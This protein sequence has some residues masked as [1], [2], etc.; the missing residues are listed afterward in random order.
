MVK[1]E[2][3]A[4]EGTMDK[5]VAIVEARV[6]VSIAI[7][8]LL[9]ACTHGYLGIPASSNQCDWMNKIRFAR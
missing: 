8:C 2:G 9:I 3:T 5:V 1:A 7:E 6:T 4:G